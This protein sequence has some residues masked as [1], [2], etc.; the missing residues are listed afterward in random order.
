[1]LKDNEAI[2]WLKKMGLSTSGYSLLVLNA[3]NN[4]KIVT[5]VERFKKSYHSDHKVLY[6]ECKPTH[7][8]ILSVGPSKLRSNITVIGFVELLP[9]I[10][11]QI[12]GVVASLGLAEDEI[13]QSFIDKINSRNFIDDAPI[14]EVFLQGLAPVSS[15]PSQAKLLVKP[16]EGHP[17][18]HEDAAGRMDYSD[19][20]LFDNVISGQHVADYIP[21]QEGIS[22]R[23][24]YGD[25]INVEAV[26]DKPISCG[27]GIVY[28]EVQRKYFTEAAGYLV[29]DERKLSLVTT[30]VVQGDVDLNVGH[31]NF[32][33]N[34]HI[35][36]DVLPDFSVQASGNVRIDGTVSGASINTEKGLEMTRGILGQ[37][38]SVVKTGEDA[39]LKFANETLMEIQGDLKLGKEALNSNLLCLGK[40]DSEK[41]LIKGGRMVALK[42]I[43]VASIGSELGVKTHVFLGEDYRNLKRSDEVRE[44]MLK[45]KDKFEARYEGIYTEVQYW[46]KENAEHQYTSEELEKL[47]DKISK[48]RSM[49][50]DLHLLNQ[51]FKL[52]STK[53]PEGRVMECVV[54]KNIFPGTIFFCSGAL[55]EVKEKISGPVKISGEELSR[56]HHKINVSSI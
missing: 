19:L 53:K 38:K 27:H 15:Q 54:L 23:D 51:E 24:V 39:N 50:N 18:Y 9:K 28:D 14:D 29:L 1:M 47:T 40:I 7:I 16:F 41:A 22:G 35:F 31:I 37:N 36:G 10:R 13:D 4:K 2:N 11:T 44:L 32:I 20:H 33:S 5:N 21:P 8:I 25:T 26:V 42:E 12:E 17:E 45:T 49:A 55:L 43:N 34:V 48:V 3:S 46:S 30:Y 52:L 56:G 6:I